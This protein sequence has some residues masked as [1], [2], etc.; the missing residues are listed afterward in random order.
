ME[1]GTE[2]IQDKNISPHPVSLQDSQPRGHAE[3][4][5][6]HSS[7]HAAPGREAGPG[8]QAHLLAT[9]V[10]LAFLEGG[11]LGWACL[12]GG[13]ALAFFSSSDLALCRS[14]SLSFFRFSFS[15]FSFF[16]FGLFT[17]A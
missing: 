16:L 4:H 9:V 11:F 15:F 8:R 12:V 10:L 14:L 5:T 7:R 3:P 17:G 13:A 2:G 6:Q 1:E